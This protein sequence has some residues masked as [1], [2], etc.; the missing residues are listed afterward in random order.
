MSLLLATVSG[1]SP[2]GTPWRWVDDEDADMILRKNVAG[3]SVGCE[4][5]NTADGTPFT[6]TAAVFVTLDNGAQA[7]GGGTVSHKGNGFHVYLPTQA[8]TNANAMGFTFTGSGAMSRTRS[9]VGVAFDPSDAV[10][11]GL[12]ALP[13]AAAEAAGGLYTRG[14]GAGQINQQANGQIDVNLERWINVAPLALVAQ[15]V[16]SLVGAVTNGVIAAASFA[17]GAL[18]A[19]WSTTTRT[20]TAGTNIVLAKG[21]GVTGFTDLDAA[22]V[23]TATGLASA[24]LDTQ[25]AAISALLDNEVALILAAVD[26]EIAA[27]LAK[28]NA[29]PASP[30]AVSDIPTL[31]AIADAVWDEVLAGHLTGG[32]TG[33]ALNGAG[34]AGDPW[35][36]TLPG[37]Y[38]AGTAGNIVG[39]RLDVAVSTRSSHAAAD[40][41]AVGTRTL[42][43]FGTLVSDIWANVTRT[44][45]AGTNIVLAKGTGI[46][47]FN[48]LSAAQVNAEADTALADVGVTLTV[49]GR[50]D[51]AISSR[52]A[53]AGYTAPLDAAATRAAIGL[54]SA[55]LDSQLSALALAIA[56]VDD[57]LDTEIATLLAAVDTE[58]P[59]ILADTNELQTDWTNGGRLDLLIDSIL[60]YVDDLELRLTSTLAAKLSAH[61][62]AILTV[63]IGAGST[64]TAVKLS[65][66]NG[67]APSSVDNFYKDRVLIFTSGALAGQ[68]T[69]I[70][71]YTGLTTTANG[72]ALTSA[73]SNGDT[74]VIV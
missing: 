68:A 10:R 48:D 36:A 8:E 57:F 35:T 21:V 45:T 33:A 65:T 1:G 69:S 53:T 38:G 73:P 34:A 74:A 61:A 28:V 18:D 60:G 49:T 2:P 37:A 16:P 72:P 25:L 51:A 50:I 6:G 62:A 47:G 44:L 52:L 41:W 71:T 24:N 43:G 23:R 20:L 31:A 59:A 19:V 58:I 39:N 40:I 70:D 27:I 29:L 12:T 46:T 54:A 4:M 17:A 11:I 67:A 42:T 9:R 7:S 15:R 5:I 26:T 56:A 22:G 63:T 55:N 13:N 32:T 14:A 3:Q 30:A 66:V 64:S